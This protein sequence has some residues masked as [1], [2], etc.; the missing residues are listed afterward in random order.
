MAASTGGVGGGSERDQAELEV[1]RC[2]ANLTAG[3]LAHAATYLGR[4]LAHDPSLQSAYASLGEL[5]DA[6]GSSA[7]TRELFKGDGIMVAPGNAA[8]I[9]ALLAEEGEISRAVELLGSL[10]AADPGKPW[11]VA[12]C[13][14]PDLGLS[15]PE[16]S[17]RKEI[18]DAL[19]QRYLHAAEAVGRRPTQLHDPL[20]AHPADLPGR[21][22]QDRASGP[23]GS[24]RA[25]CACRDGR[26]RT[27]QEFDA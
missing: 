19:G 6:A 25:A 4:A 5:A 22:T 20:A 11:T 17:V 15:L 16:I 2:D 7:T 13:F 14:S 26:G 12:P 24:G 18:A 27:P 23:K 9:I 21:G 10:V 3:N 1:Q 8:A